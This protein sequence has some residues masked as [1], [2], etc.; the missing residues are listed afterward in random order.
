MHRMYFFEAF[1]AVVHAEHVARLL[2]LTGSFA[3]QH[4]VPFFSYVLHTQM[5]HS[6]RTTSRLD[7]GKD[8]HRPH[9]G[10]L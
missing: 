4:K 7:I 2:H 5:W 6:N 3:W 1:M 9:Q 8:G 10:D